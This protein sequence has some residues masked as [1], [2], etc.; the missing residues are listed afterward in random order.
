VLGHRQSTQE[1]LRVQHTWLAGADS[2]RLALILEF[3]VGTQ[4]FPAVLRTGQIIDAEI[5]YFEGEP[6][7]R[8][9][10]KQ[11]FES[12]SLHPSL[13]MPVDVLGMQSRFA[14][15]L[16]INPW[17]DTWPVVLGPVTVSIRGDQV[18]FIDAD[19][20]HV[21]ARSGLKHAWHLEALAGG[22]SLALFGLWNGRAFDPIT[23]AHQGRLFSLGHVGA[24]PVLAKVA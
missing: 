6:P 24:L 7:L 8:A 17:L 19:G 15:L 1:Q 21:A 2:G 9:L 22:G 13:Q 16:A 23:V 3:A 10:I 12:G 14:A 4:P 20:R 18:R 5:V 11:R